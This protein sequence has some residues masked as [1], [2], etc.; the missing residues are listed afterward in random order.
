MLEQHGFTE[1]TLLMEVR[2][3]NVTQKVQACVS[4]GHTVNGAPPPALL[5]LTLTPTLTLTLNPDT[6]PNP[7]PNPSPEP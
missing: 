3:G 6:N 2:A 7:N 5:T 1:H 4:A